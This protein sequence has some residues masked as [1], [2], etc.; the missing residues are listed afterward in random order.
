MQHIL[1]Y[2]GN[3]KYPI[4]INVDVNIPVVKGLAEAFLKDV[5]EIDEMTRVNVYC[6]GSSGAIMAAIFATIVPNVIILHVKK[7]GEASHSEI[8]NFD[9]YISKFNCIHVIIDDFM[10]TGN[11]LETIYARV[12]KDVKIDIDYLILGRG[13]YNRI[14]KLSYEPKKLISSAD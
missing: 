2:R 14:T 4:G 3:V 12:T 13:D 9:R 8:T 10:V 1:T 5:G 7:D 6:M 11:T